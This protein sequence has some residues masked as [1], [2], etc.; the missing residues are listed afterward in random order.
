MIAFT[1]SSVLFLGLLLLNM[2]FSQL[3]IA[4][5]RYSV[6]FKLLLSGVRSLAS[7][8][9]SH[10]VV[11]FLMTLLVLNLLGN[12]PG[13]SVPTM[14]YFFTCSVSL[15]IWVS[16]ILVVCTTQLKPFLAHILPYGSPLG[17]ILLLPLIEAFSHLIR[18]FTLIIR[19]STNLSSGHIL[20][21]MFSFFSLSSF[22]LTVRI[23]LVLFVLFMLELMISA[24]Q[25]YIFTSLAH[26]YISETE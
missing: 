17:L 4:P 26:M 10:F 20:L 6:L 5:T 3:F 2:L 25:A 8:I 9:Y 23:S 16:L 14:F 7:G 11:S 22:S 12:I 21:Y 24:L 19:L 15:T 1:L 13:F 18:P